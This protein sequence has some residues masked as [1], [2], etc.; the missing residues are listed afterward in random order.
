MSPEFNIDQI[1]ELARI[2]LK[3]EEKEKLAK[4]LENILKYVKELQALD[5]GNTEPT[6]HALPMENVFRKDEVKSREVRDRVLKYAPK[7]EGN[8]FKVPKVIERD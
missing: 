4:D 5:L 1:A 6:T 7:Q 3:S 2:R 8:F